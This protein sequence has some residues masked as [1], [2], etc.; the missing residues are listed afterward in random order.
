MTAH[1]LGRFSEGD[2]VYLTKTENPKIHFPFFIFSFFF[3]FL[4]KKKTIQNV[5]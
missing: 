2:D 5:I 1:L 4:H 3:T